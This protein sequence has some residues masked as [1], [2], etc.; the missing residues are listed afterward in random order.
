MSAA[1]PDENKMQCARSVTTRE[2]GTDCVKPEATRDKHE[3]LR[4]NH[5]ISMRM[6]LEVLNS[7]DLIITTS[8]SDSECASV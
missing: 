7:I 4:E 2:T 1:N 5:R 8:T 6:D 3:I